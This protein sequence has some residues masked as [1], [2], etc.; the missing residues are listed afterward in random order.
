[1]CLAK[2]KTK[3]IIAANKEESEALYIVLNGRVA[4]YRK[5]NEY[6]ESDEIIF[7]NSGSCFGHMYNWNINFITL[8]MEETL[9]AVLN[10]K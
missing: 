8:A 5:A 4:F 7:L 2:F 3:D 1:M 9:V 6:Y 10:K